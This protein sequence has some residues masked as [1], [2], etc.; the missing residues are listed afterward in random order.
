MKKTTTEAKA[1]PKATPRGSAA[2]RRKVEEENVRS[3]TKTGDDKSYTISLPI[4][5]IRAFR[6]KE[7]QKL[8]L[9]VDKK[10]KTILIRDWVKGK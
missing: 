4:E 7:H 6:W 9:S 5:A 2:G 3:L 8:V 1:K 10:S